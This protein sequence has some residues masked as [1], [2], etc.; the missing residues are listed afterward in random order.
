MQMLPKSNPVCPLRLLGPAA[1]AV[2]PSLLVLF[3]GQVSDQVEVLLSQAWRLRSRVLSHRPLSPQPLRELDVQIILLPAEEEGQGDRQEGEEGPVRVALGS[4]AVAVVDKLLDTLQQR[5]SLRPMELA[6]GA[7]VGA[8]AEGEGSATTT[9]A[10][11]A[12]ARY[13]IAVL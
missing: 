6:L 10:A 8:T 4:A 5:S 13:L 11:A 7:P 9:A 1:P 3:S 12:A 2:R